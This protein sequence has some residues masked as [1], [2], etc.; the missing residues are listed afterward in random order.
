M[1]N[2]KNLVPAGYS[3]DWW[4]SDLLEELSGE[5]EI[6]EF[7]KIMNITRDSCPKGIPGTPRNNDSDDSERFKVRLNWQRFLITQQLD[8]TQAKSIAQRFKTSLPPPHNR[9]FLDLPIE[10]VPSLLNVLKDAKIEH[11]DS[12]LLYTSPSPRDGLLSR[13]PSS[14]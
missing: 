5:N 14:A 1:E 7:C 11:Y 10:W 13:M 3:I 8:W 2:N 9:W 4:A 6:D 12:C